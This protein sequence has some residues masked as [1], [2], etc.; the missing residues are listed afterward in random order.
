MNFPFISSLIIF[1]RGLCVCVGGGCP[2]GGASERP[3]AL[4][5][6]DFIREEVRDVVMMCESWRRRRMMRSSPGNH[7]PTSGGAKRS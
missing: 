2:K 5:L 6:R 7:I 4:S 3:G 1:V